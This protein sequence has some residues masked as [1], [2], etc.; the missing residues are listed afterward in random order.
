MNFD[1][2]VLTS[3]LPVVLLILVGVAVGRAKLVRQEAVRDLSNLVFLVLTQALLFRTMSSVHLERLDVRPGGAASG[4]L[5]GAGGAAAAA[6]VRGDCL[7]GT[8]M[9]SSARRRAREACSCAKISA[10]PP[11]S[12]TSPMLRRVRA[13]LAMRL[14]CQKTASAEEDEASPA[15]VWAHATPLKHSLAGCAMRCWAA[16]QCE[17]PSASTVDTKF[18]KIRRNIYYKL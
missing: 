1:H 5:R 13:A 18:K 15:H 9:P 2:P 16:C 7:W 11:P 14:R 8:S 4:R 10:R 17:G 12:P 6:G 3:L